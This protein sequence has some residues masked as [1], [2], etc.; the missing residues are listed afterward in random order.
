[1]V[2]ALSF[3]AYRNRYKFFT[4]E[5]EGSGSFA[6]LHVGE[7]GVTDEENRRGIRLLPGSAGL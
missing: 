3:P 7:G 6:F 2:A 4:T 1:M 5:D